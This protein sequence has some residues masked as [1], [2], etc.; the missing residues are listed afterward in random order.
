MLRPEDL[1]V[2]L[3]YVWKHANYGGSNIFQLFDTAEK[4]NHLV[5]SRRRWLESQERDGARQKS[6]RN[7][8]CDL[9]Y[10]GAKAKAP[11]SPTALCKL[12]CLS[13]ARRRPEKKTCGK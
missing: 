1:E 9:G 7:E 5:A 10:R 13:K 8:W 3:W 6:G 2:C 12:L 4:P 11:P